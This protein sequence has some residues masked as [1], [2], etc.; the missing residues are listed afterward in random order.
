[1][2]AVTG[3]AGMPFTPHYNVHKARKPNCPTNK[4]AGY[5]LATTAYR[6]ATTGYHR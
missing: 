6:L 5:H 1:V 3:T 2:Q 4:E